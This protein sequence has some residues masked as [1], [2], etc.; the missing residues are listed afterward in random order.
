MFSTKTIAA[1]E[2]ILGISY[3]EAERAFMLDN[4]SGQIELAKRRR[5]TRLPH[6]LAPATRFD[7]RLPGFAMPTHAPPPAVESDPGPIP[8]TAEDICFAPVTQLSGWIRTQAISAERLAELYLDRIARLG[9]KLECVATLT[10]DLAIQQ[11]RRADALL[12]KGTWLGPL[13]GV[14]WGAKDLLDTSGVLT[15]WGAEPFS[16]RVPREDATVVQRLAAAGAVMLAKLTLGALA[17]GDIW[18]G[19]VTRNPWNLAE[20]SSGSSA[21]SGS[22]TAAGLVGFSLGTETL[23]S[24][25]APALRCGATGLRPTFGRVPRTGAMPLCWT[26]DKIGPICRSVADTSLVLA[27]I[28]GGD[29]TDPCSIDAPFGVDLAAPISGLRLGYYPADFAEPG[30]EDLDRAV[31][32]HARDLGMTLVEL[33]RPDL[34]YDALMNTLFAEAAASFEALT[35]DNE[36][37]RLTWQEPGAWP[38]T[39]R[40]ARFLS[41]IDHIQLDRLRRKVM[42]TMDQAF[43]SIDAIVGPCLAGPMLIITNFTGHPCLALRV[44]FRSSPTRERL[45]LA[46][47]R[48]DQG[49]QGTGESFTVPHSISLYGRLFD[50]GAILR[51]GAALEARL[52]VAGRRPPLTA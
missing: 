17:Y 6:D 11:A 28:N 48:L 41:A 36:D 52:D 37:D 46:E 9:P 33:T 30:A 20:G 14:P 43:D 44:G 1:G 40:K 39:F 5:Q 18:Y 16:D 35:L 25:V 15:G 12:A 42:Q 32:G 3:T 31:L 10:A 27:A 34:P 26:L 23:G 29:P 49:Q 45:S 21:G 7:P 4:L 19:G 47:A 13:H 8:D 22:A 24:I 38:N 2:D 51:I 50:E